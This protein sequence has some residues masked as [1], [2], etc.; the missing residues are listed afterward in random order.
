M[1]ACHFESAGVKDGPANAQVIPSRGVKVAGVLGPA[2]P[3]EKK[4]AAVA[5]Q[6]VGMGGTTLWR[7]AGLVRPSDRTS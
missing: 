4:G 3:M 1:R 7:L 6:S 2:A 5:E